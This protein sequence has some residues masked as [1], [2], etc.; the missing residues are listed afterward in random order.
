[1]E[2]N[3]LSYLIYQAIAPMEQ[4]ARH[5]II[6]V[7]I[8]DDV[9]LQANKRKVFVPSGQLPFGKMGAIFYVPPGTSDG[10]NL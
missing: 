6:F 7:N 4:K 8:K 10:I 2:R 5:I 3:I 9:L 1:M